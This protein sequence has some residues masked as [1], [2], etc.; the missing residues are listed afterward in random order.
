MFRRFCSYAM[1][2]ARFSSSLSRS[3]P[4]LGRPAEPKPAPLT[5]DFRRFAGGVGPMPF[6]E[7]EDSFRARLGWRPCGRNFSDCG[8][9]GSD[10]VS[11]HFEAFSCQQCWIIR[12]ACLGFEA[13]CES[14]RDSPFTMLV[15]GAMGSVG[16]CCDILHRGVDFCAVICALRGTAL[17]IGA[18][19]WVEAPIVPGAQ[20]SVNG[21]DAGSVHAQKN[22]AK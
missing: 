6:A 7:S 16:C 4:A 9:G 10:G 1:W 2:F 15:A 11:S 8:A 20:H 12:E 3:F 22:P 17:G 19:T 13:S 18:G 14:E 5:I 21:S